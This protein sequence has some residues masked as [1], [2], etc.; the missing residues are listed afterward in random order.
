[1]AQEILHAAGQIY[2]AA[3]LGL[4]MLVMLPVAL[5]F[6]LDFRALFNQPPVETKPEPE[7]K[8]VTDAPIVAEPIKAV[9]EQ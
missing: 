5:D 8:I 7:I 4:G 3:C 9:S 6:V 2:I 1:M